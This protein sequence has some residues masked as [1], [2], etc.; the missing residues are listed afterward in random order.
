MS[1]YM[2]KHTA[3]KLIGSPPGYVGYD[4]GGQLTEKIRRKPYSVVLLDE[5]EKAHP[6]IFNMLLQVLEDGRLTD[7]QGR[8]V[9]FDNS[10][11][12]M[13]SNLGTNFKE[14]SIG[15]GNTNSIQ[16]ENSIK[17]ALKETFKPEFINRIDEIVIFEKLNKEELYDIIDIM[18]DEVSEDLSEK[19]IKVHFTKEVKDFILKVGY[20]EKMVQ[21]N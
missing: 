17:D 20:D 8:T 19:N 3:S 21:G 4:E 11:I 16:I 1:E 14:S 13:T 9:F 18:F 2:E 12:I 7:N 6:D 10:V 5:I 15:F